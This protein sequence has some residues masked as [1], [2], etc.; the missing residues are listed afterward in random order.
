VIDRHAEEISRELDGSYI[1]LTITFLFDEI[2]GLI[3]HKYKF[4]Y[5]SMIYV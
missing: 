4:K 3:V 5:E 2:I 1:L